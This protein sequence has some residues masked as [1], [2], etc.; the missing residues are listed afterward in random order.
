MAPDEIGVLVA[1]I[2]FTVGGFILAH[3]AKKT[4]TQNN[5]DNKK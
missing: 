5:D 1:V 2:L 4:R 3:F